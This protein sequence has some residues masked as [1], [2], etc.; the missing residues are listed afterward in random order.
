M[1]D[2]ISMLSGVPKFGPISTYG[3]PVR[4]ALGELTCLG[5]SPETLKLAG[6][7]AA[8]AAPP[9]PEVEFAIVN[10]PTDQLYGALESIETALKARGLKMPMPSGTDDAMLKFAGLFVGGVALYYLLSKRS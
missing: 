4:G 9:P 3:K 6:L 7:M 2:M 1:A 5:C 10:L 8:K